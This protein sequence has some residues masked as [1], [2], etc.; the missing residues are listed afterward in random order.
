MHPY[1]LVLEPALAPLELPRRRGKA[2]VVPTEHLAHR[3]CRD[4]IICRFNGGRLY[5]N[6]TLYA[7]YGQD[8]VVDLNDGNGF[9]RVVD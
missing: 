5:F 1:L 2:L 7:N 6:D 4:I 3:I 9:N 8:G